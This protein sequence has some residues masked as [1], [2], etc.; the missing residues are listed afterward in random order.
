DCCLSTARSYKIASPIFIAFPC[1]LPP[2]CSVQSD[3]RDGETTP[4]S[5]DLSAVWCCMSAEA[6]S[7]LLG[8]PTH[9]PQPRSYEPCPEPTLRPDTRAGD[10]ESPSDQCRPHA[11]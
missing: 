9:P 7:E 4:R 8:G 1:M 11:F 5:L 2:C 3:F 6:W 10:A